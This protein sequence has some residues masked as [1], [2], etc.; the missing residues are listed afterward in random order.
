MSDISEHKAAIV[1]AAITP[2]QD[3]HFFPTVSKVAVQNTSPWRDSG[4]VVQLAFMCG[5]ERIWRDTRALANLAVVGAIRQQH[6]RSSH[7]PGAG[8]D[9]AEGL[10]A[11]HQASQCGDRAEA[12]LHGSLEP[13]RHYVFFAEGRRP[14]A[15]RHSPSAGARAAPFRGVRPASVSS[16]R[17]STMTRTR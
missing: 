15:H 2:T 7:R 10:Q 17:S 8:G 12:E 4:R 3:R 11:C 14:R 13:A 1:V 16:W 5:L 9:R 6:L